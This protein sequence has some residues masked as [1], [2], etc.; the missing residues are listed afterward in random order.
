M[1]AVKV[2][3]WDLAGDMI[4]WRNLSRLDNGRDKSVLIG[5]FPVASKI[6]IISIVLIKF[7]EHFYCVPGIV[8]SAL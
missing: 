2:G 5:W 3:S 1:W 6:I 8:L 7:I 4:T